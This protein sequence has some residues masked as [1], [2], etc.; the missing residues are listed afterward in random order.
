MYK[1]KNGGK[2]SW[3]EE[4]SCET[5]KHEFT[6]YRQIKGGER[7]E[8]I[9]RHIVEVCTQWTARRSYQ[10]VL[11]HFGRV[12][13][14]Q[15]DIIKNG[16]IYGDYVE[17]F[18]MM[19]KAFGVSDS[20]MMNEMQMMMKTVPTNQYY[21]H[22]KVFLSKETGLNKNIVRSALSRTKSKVG[23]EDILKSFKLK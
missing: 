7:E 9:R 15:K 18:D 11:G 8:T 23:Y 14:H 20:I 22:L 2:L 6:H 21:E 16:L 19:L 5:L 4:Y 10:D 3:L 12:P 13:V 17:N 1:L